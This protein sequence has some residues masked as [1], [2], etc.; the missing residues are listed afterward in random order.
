L[1]N[2]SF[3]LHRVNAKLFGNAYARHRTIR[4]AT[5][6]VQESTAQSGLHTHLPN[7]KSVE[8]SWSWTIGQGVKVSNTALSGAG[9]FFFQ[10]HFARDIAKVVRE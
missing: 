4:L 6:A 5:Y 8:V 10:A 2:Q 9:E 7:N 1:A 3:A